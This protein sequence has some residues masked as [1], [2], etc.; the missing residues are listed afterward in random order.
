MNTTKIKT[1]NKDFVN[2]FNKTI[3]IVNELIDIC[4]TC[5]EMSLVYDYFDNRMRLCDGVL[6]EHLGED[7]WE[8]FNHYFT[9]NSIK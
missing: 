5:N 4:D 7:W 9:G 6:T 3:N 2:K 1:H 8:E